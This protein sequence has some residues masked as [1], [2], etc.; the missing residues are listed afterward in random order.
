[1]RMIFVLDIFDGVA[2]HAVR[3][4]RERYAPVGGYSRLLRASDPVRIVEYIKP[5]EVYVADLNLIRGIGKNNLSA[6]K[7]ISSIARTMLDA[8]VGTMAG[9]NRAQKA[10]NSVILGTETAPLGLIKNASELYDN[11]I[12]SIDTKNGKMAALD[13]KLCIPPLEAVKKMN[14]FPLGDLIILFMERVGARSGVDVR[15]LKKAV[16]VSRHGIIAGGGVRGMEDIEALGSIGVEGVLVSTAV[17][18]GAVPPG[19]LR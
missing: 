1:M 5:R 12:A 19:K 11:I 4:E 7:R 18:D 8:G 15:F 2:V 14:E 17:H 13:E 10:A 16:G 6:V 3:G 9:V